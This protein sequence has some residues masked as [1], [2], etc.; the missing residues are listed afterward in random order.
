MTVKITAEN[1]EQFA[2]FEKIVIERGIDPTT[3]EHV[4]SN[5]IGTPEVCF[6]W[7]GSK[8]KIHPRGNGW[9]LTVSTKEKINYIEIHSLPEGKC[10]IIVAYIEV[11][12]I[13]IADHL[14]TAFIFR[15]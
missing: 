11:T 8:D 12:F 1:S 9:E 6:N 7:K 2:K 3:V 14:I 5:I 10:E 13:Y 15:D 4:R